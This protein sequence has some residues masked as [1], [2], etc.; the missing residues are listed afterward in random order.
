MQKATAV[1]VGDEKKD[2]VEVN[3]RYTVE[4]GVIK[5]IRC[6]ETPANRICINLR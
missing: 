4:N 6:M 1:Y 3:I 5:E 2:N